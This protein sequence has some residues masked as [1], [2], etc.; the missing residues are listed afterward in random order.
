MGKNQTSQI[1]NILLSVKDASVAI[2]VS[3]K[4][5]RLLIASGRLKAVNLGKR[6]TRISLQELT[7]FAQG[8]GC[9]VVLPSSSLPFNYDKRERNKKNANAKPETGCINKT[10]KCRMTPACEKA[11]EGVTHK[12]HYTMAEVMSKFNI[13]YGRLYEI[14]NRYQL[15]SVHAWGTT[16][17]TMKN[18]A[19]RSR[20]H[21][22]PVSTSC[23]SMV[24]V[25]RKYA[26]LPRH[27][28][29]VSRKP[30]AA[31][32][33]STLRQTGKQPERK[34]RRQVPVPRRNGHEVGCENTNVGT[35]CSDG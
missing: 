17:S 10:A 1:P 20:K 27:T 11:P 5:V 29:S 4:M 18:R 21:I 3:S 34:L 24:W 7:D 28:M 19:R 8:Q 9:N 31:G 32:L 22:T 2:S 16:P 12:T 33:T 35:T 25:R 30:R 14:R 23:R 15:A 26:A 6:M 13:K